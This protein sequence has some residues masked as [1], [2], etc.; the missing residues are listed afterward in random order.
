M[1]TYQEAFEV[2]AKRK[3][4]PYGA[5]LTY[6]ESDNKFVVYDDPIIQSYWKAWQFAL[7]LSALEEP[8]WSDSETLL[9]ECWKNPHQTMQDRLLMADGAVSFRDKV[10]A[11]L[12]DQLANSQTFRQSEVEAICKRVANEIMACARMN[13]IRKIDSV[14][15][16]AINDAALSR[17][18]GA[19]DKKR[20]DIVKSSRIIEVKR[21][22][23]ELWASKLNVTLPLTRDPTG[24]FTYKNPKTEGAWMGWQAALSQ[25]CK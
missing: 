4:A 16:E 11:N 10:I 7:T 20:N 22:D 21:K 17:G 5:K 1:N 2:Y 8:D 14:I 15:E 23:F 24:L 19:L 18:E 3:F 9:S 12:R 13:Q 6:W 25:K